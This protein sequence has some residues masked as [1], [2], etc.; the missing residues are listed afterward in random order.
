MKFLKNTLTSRQRPKNYINFK[1]I[2]D[3]LNRIAENF[4]VYPSQIIIFR[5]R[6]FA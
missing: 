6:Y 2:K 3:K 1:R 4:K 5:S